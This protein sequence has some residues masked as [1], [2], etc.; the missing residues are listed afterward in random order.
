[1]ANTMK[2]I[3]PQL[4][5]T[6]LGGSVIAP[7]QFGNQAGT[8]E[9]EYK[10]TASQTYGVGDLV[11][12]DTNGTVAICTTT[13]G[14]TGGNVL[15]SAVLGQAEKAATG[16]TGAQAVGHFIRPDDIYIMNI[17]HHTAASATSNQNQLGTVRGIQKTVSTDNT[18]S[19]VVWAVDI[20]NAVENTTLSNA[21]VQIVGFPKTGTLSDGTLTQS[22]AGPGDTYGLVYVKFLP[23]SIA[24]N[25]S[26]FRRNLQRG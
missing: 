1:M 10:E 17:Y 2:L 23:Y 12:L 13:A 9:N 5:G 21:Y 20:E 18:Q 19:A 16:T 6:N 26:T 8:E 24:S 4:V 3:N 25:G 22:G 7:G 15:N 11:Y 14:A